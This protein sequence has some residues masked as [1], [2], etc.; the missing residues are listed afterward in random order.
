MKY[1]KCLFVAVITLISVSC[2]TPSPSVKVVERERVVQVVDSASFYALLECDSTNNVL[3]KS[4][5]LKST[6][7]IKQDFKFDN[8]KI[9]LSMLNLRDS[10]IYNYKDSIIFVPNYN[11]YHP[12][13]NYLTITVASI[14]G[15]CA[16]MLL[17]K[18]GGL[19][20]FRSFF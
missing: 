8:G 13:N 20:R 11:P 6:P 7:S 12:Q 15:I 5:S 10:I 2:R 18:I 9:E 17:K 4:Y 1:L 16:L 19:A 14:I 3:V